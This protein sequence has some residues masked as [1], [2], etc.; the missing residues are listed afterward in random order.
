MA[1]K[2]TMIEQAETM[3]DKIQVPASQWRPHIR[4]GFTLIE[5]LVVIAIIAILAGMLLPAL[6]R[7]KSKAHTARCL[8]NLRQ[9]GITMLLYTQDNNDHFPFSGRGWPQLPM[10]D[11]MKLFN[12][13]VPTNGSAF[14]V[15]PADKPPPWNFAWTMNI[16]STFNIKTNEL[17]FADSYYYYLR[18]YNDDTDNLKL[19]QR[20]A[21]Q[22]RSPAKK[23]IMGCFAESENAKIG[24]H[25]GLAHGENGFPILFVDG[26]SAYTKYSSLKY[27]TDFSKSNL[28]WTPGGLTGEDLK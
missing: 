25:H 12:P 19:Q 20:S 7:A 1:Q 18:F 3:K 6:S 2:L 15:C 5:L 22:V 27:Q 28:D 16:G 21:E 9:F 26:H 11:L 17:L 24:D 10:V 14:Y 23:A 8:S 4:A 13:Y